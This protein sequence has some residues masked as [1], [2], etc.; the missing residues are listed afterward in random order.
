MKALTTLVL[1]FS[2]VTVV[3]AQ[4]KPRL[5]L[6]K[7][8]I[9]R[10]QGTLTLKEAMNMMEG[11]PEAYNY[12]KKA[13]TNST[14]SAI[15]GGIG[16][17]LIGYPIGQSIAGG[18]A[19]WGLAGIGA[20]VFLIAIPFNSAYKKNATIATELYNEANHKALSQNVQFEI[21]ILESGLG[22]RVSF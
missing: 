5:E 21:G 20:G 10:P 9:F 6:E 15:F 11:Y 19:N 16:G 7:G 18:D 1:F 8:K 14:I 17:Y 4:D 13:R 3:Q 12:M 22:L 2:L